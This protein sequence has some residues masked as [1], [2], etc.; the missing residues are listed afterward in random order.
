[1]SEFKVNTITN[2][3]GSH[4]PQV[5]GITTFKSSGMQLPSGPT[6]MRGNGKSRG[7]GYIAGGR[8]SPVY[9]SDIDFIQINTRGDSQEFGDLRYAVNGPKGN[10]NTTRS[11]FAAGYYPS[12]SPSAGNI[13]NIDLML[14]ASLGGVTGFGELTIDGGQNGA[15][16]TACND[17]IAIY[18]GGGTNYTRGMEKINFATTGDGVAFGDLVN[19]GIADKDGDNP[20][21]RNINV[22]NL[23]SPT[24]AL[25]VGGDDNPGTDY[26]VIQYVTF[27]S[28]GDA[29]RFGEA[30]TVYS[31]T[32]AVSDG[33]RGIYAGGETP[34]RT[35]HIEYISIVSFGTTQEFGDLTQARRSL[36]ACNDS[37][38]ACFVAGDDGSSSPN[39]C[40]I[41]DYITIK[42]TGDAADFG[43][44]SYHTVRNPASSSDSHGGLA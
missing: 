25:F 24:R 41:I 10:G 21:L 23:G 39:N 14:H 1:M 7:R 16:G 28:L 12:L 43:D 20:G 26:N 6:T 13:K 8:R 15:Q 27:A 2:R 19:L 36:G 35:N 18:A 11:V 3:D 38:R 34:N 5:C 31:N 32:A 37:L 4:G 9:Y 33:T 29:V 40:N 22:G 44:L 42:T 30:S 17:T